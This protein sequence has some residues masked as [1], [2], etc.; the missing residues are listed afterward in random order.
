MGSCNRGFHA[1]DDEDKDW[2]KNS[3]VIGS[4]V[5]CLEGLDER[6]RQVG[7]EPDGV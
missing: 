6:G 7:D 1:Q 2:T 3:D 4:E 5:A